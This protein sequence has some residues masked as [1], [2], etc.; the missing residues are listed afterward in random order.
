MHNIRKINNAVIISGNTGKNKEHEEFSFPLD[1]EKSLEKA[2]NHVEQTITT[3]AEKALER[4]IKQLNNIFNE[5]NE[6][7]SAEEN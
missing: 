4:T 6:D 2:T 1:D 7:D 3:V 5:K